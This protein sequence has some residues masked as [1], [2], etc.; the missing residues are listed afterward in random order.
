FILPSLN[1]DIIEDRVLY[2]LK[3]TK[4]GFDDE[5]VN[6]LAK[7]KLIIQ[8]KSEYKDIEQK[9]LNIN[10][11]LQKHIGLR[12]AIYY[13]SLTNIDIYSLTLEN[14]VDYELEQLN[15]LKQEET[16]KISY[17]KQLALSL[18]KC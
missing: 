10:K 1:Y 14:I 6:V 13:S 7:Y 4:S 11:E 15:F 18:D 16:T 12:V 5:L 2:F 17:K 9:I 3:N 8:K